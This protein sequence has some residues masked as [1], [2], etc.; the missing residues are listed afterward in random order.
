MILLRGPFD[1]D[2]RPVRSRVGGVS[3]L[4]PDARDTIRVPATPYGGRGFSRRCRWSESIV[5]DRLNPLDVSF[6]YIEDPTTPMHV[7]SVALFTV[8]DPGFD[9]DRLV[10]LIRKRIA[11]VPRYR[12]RIRWIPGHIAS[13]VWV[14]DENF[15]MA[16]HVRRSALP[17]PGPRTSLASW[18]PGS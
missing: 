3:P 11:F 8:P 6:L 16:Y 15:D 14:D 5:S 2:P 10:R 4:K 9:Y 7:G 17:R 12:Q 1:Q 13:P 18:S